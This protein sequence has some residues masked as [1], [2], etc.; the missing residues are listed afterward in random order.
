MKMYKPLSKRV[1][2]CAECDEEFSTQYNLKIHFEKQ[3]PGKL[4]RVKGQTFLNFSAPSKRGYDGN[5]VQNAEERNE[6]ESSVS[7]VANTSNHRRN[8]DNAIR[9]DLEHQQ[10]E[11][12]S[13]STSS[14]SNHLLEQMQILLD[15]L[16]FKDS[17]S[18]D[19]GKLRGQHVIDSHSTQVVYDHEIV[20]RI[21]VCVS[22]NDLQTII[23][24]TF[25]VDRINEFMLCKTCISNPENIFLGSG[26]QNVVGAFSIQGV[27]YEKER[28]QSR[29]L[30][31]LKENLINHLKHTD[32]SKV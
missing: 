14:S 8:E 30:R 13:A 6:A 25:S 7:T 5:Q 16:K 15:E 17:G 20:D 32:A 19:G 1:V 18:N 12:V 9:G 4:C 21:K 26:K 29:P 23:K 3:H 27:E 31:H 10:T 2:Q 28:V 24:E 22:L 11:P